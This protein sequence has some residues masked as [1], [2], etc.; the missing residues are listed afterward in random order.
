M[1][2][3]LFYGV[4]LSARLRLSRAAS[5]LGAELVSQAVGDP[6]AEPD[7]VVIDIDRAAASVADLARLHPQAQVL[8][9]YSHIDDDKR[10][11]AE[12]AGVQ[13]IPRSRFWRE[14]ARLIAQALE[15]G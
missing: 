13:A 14:T 10:I 9:Y 5:K 15:Q 7:V 3:I 6:E 12:E 4:D 8:G 1:T 11:S 2:R